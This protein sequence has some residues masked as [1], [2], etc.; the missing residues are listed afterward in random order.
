MLVL[1]SKRDSGL[2]S[3]LPD[4]RAVENPVQP[5]GR[6]V[7]EGVTRLFIDA[8]R[9]ICN[10]PYALLA[11]DQRNILVGDSFFSIV[12]RAKAMGFAKGSTHPTG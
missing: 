4:G 9:R 6:V 8:E 11:D 2:P 10:P 7:A 5:V 3:D 1:A 12:N